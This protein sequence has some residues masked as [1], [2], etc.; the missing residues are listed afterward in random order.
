M[1][2]WREGKYNLAA[3]QMLERWQ[4]GQQ[5]TQNA[6]AESNRNEVAEIMGAQDRCHGDPT[7]DS[8]D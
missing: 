8:E 4:E 1:S 2:R 3:A 5:V 7:D 6:Q